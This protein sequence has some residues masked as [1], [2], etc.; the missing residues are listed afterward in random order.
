MGFIG[1]LCCQLHPSWRIGK[2]SLWVYSGSKPDLKSLLSMFLNLF[3]YALQ[4]FVHLWHTF[5][6]WITYL[7][8][9]W[10]PGVKGCLELAGLKPWTLRFPICYVTSQTR[11]PKIVYVVRPL[12][13]LVEFNLLLDASRKLFAQIPSL[14]HYDVFQFSASD[15]FQIGCR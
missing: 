3:K 15:S 11:L 4:I 9:I 12:W 5:W 14:L 13:I 2:T 1:K 8:F 10:Q 7:L 6:L